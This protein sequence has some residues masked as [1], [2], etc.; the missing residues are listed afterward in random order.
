MITRRFM[1]ICL[2]APASGAFFVSLCID[3]HRTGG[4][5]AALIKWSWRPF[6]GCRRYDKS[7]PVAFR[8]GSGRIAA[9]AR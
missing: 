2:K 3:G 9:I 8:G 5:A 6:W 4:R 1:E 7:R